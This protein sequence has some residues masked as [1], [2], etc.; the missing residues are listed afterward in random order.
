MISKLYSGKKCTCLTANKSEK[1]RAVIKYVF[2]ILLSKIQKQP[3]EVFCK[4]GV[5]KN[6]TKF[7]GKH[8]CQSLY[9]NEVAGRWTTASK[10]RSSG[11]KMYSRKLIFI[12][13]CILS[14]YLKI[15]YSVFEIFTHPAFT[16]SKLTIEILE[17]GEK[18][19]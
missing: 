7:T 16:C 8:L 5:L 11:K 9:F 15:G 18:Y 6:V 12:L 19:V 1:S 2:S 17:E 10:N 14:G 4:K 3:P 13:P